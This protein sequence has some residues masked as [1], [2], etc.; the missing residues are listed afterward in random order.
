MTFGIYLCHFVFV[1]MGY[2]L[3]ALLLPSGDSCHNTHYLHGCNSLSHQLPGGQ[4]DV[5]MQM[6]QKICGVK[7]NGFKTQGVTVSSWLIIS[8]KFFIYLLSVD[9]QLFTMIDLF[10]NSSSFCHRI[11]Q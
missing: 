5:C 2:D 6:D 4:R 7:N 1:Q 8:F 11:F 10:I 3:F 9:N